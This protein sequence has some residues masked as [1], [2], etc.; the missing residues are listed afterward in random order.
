VLRVSTDLH[1]MSEHKGIQL[2]QIYDYKVQ[3][4]EEWE[5]ER[6]KAA[7]FAK[8]RVFNVRADM[9]SRKKKI[10]ALRNSST[11]GIWGTMFQ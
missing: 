9:Q 7:L 11:R 1:E 5:V 8:D 2:R 4:A 10:K 3:D 6:F